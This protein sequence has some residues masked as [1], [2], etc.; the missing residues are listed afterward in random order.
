MAV[1]WASDPVLDFQSSYA[2]SIPVVRSKKVY[3]IMLKKGVFM[4]ITVNI[5]D[6]S[7]AEKIIWFLSNLKDKGV[8]IVDSDKKIIK[9]NDID[10][11][12]LQIDSMSKTWDNEFDKVWDEL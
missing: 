9:N 12:K 2:G 8:E 1:R 11:Q 5:Q 6:N 10:I 3:G 4:Q 7:V